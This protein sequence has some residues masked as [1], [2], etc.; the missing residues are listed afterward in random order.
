MGNKLTVLK[1]RQDFYLGFFNLAI[2]FFN[3]EKRGNTFT[4][5]D[6][7]NKGPVRLISVRYNVIIYLREK[8]RRKLEVWFS[9]RKPRLAHNSCCG[10][11]WKP[12][13]K[14]EGVIRKIRA[15][16]GTECGERERSPDRSKD[17]ECGNYST[18]L[19]GFPS[20]AC[21]ANQNGNLPRDHS[22]LTPALGYLLAGEC[23]PPT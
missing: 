11:M 16:R 7:R 19:S 8:R 3:R 18:N 22:A 23:S 20:S 4:M 5:K 14:T 15:K 2:S 13:T 12:S 9:L 6:Q 17:F 1:F 10:T 21:S